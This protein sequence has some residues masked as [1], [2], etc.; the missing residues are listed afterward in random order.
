MIRKDSF[1][2]GV[3]TASHVFQEGISEFDGMYQDGDGLDDAFQAG[4]VSTWYVPRWNDT[5]SSEAFFQD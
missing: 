5:I 1:H 2:K 4:D 3:V